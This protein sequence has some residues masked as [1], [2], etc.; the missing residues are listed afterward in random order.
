MIDLAGNHTQNHNEMRYVLGAR[1]NTF[2]IK[3]FFCVSRRIRV[4]SSLSISPN[5]SRLFL[6]YH[7][8]NHKNVLNT[9]IFNGIIYLYEKLHMELLFIK[10]IRKNLIGFFVAQAGER[11]RK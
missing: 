4:Y 9:L 10:P 7:Q 11:K 2:T 3:L 6:L 8:K 1:T 5:L